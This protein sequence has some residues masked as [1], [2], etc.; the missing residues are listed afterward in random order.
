MA[1]E[2]GK[3]PGDE[4]KHGTRRGGKAGQWAEARHAMAGDEPKHGRQRAETRQAKGRNTAGDVGKKP[5]D[6]WKHGTRRQ[7][8]EETR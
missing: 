3:K 6:E 4:W 7:G 5:G 1:G 2:G 8:M